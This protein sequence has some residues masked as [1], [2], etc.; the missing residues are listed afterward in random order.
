[1]RIVFTGGTFA[2]KTSLLKLFE[3]NG[4]DTINDVGLE[5]ITKLNGEIGQ[6]KQKQFRKEHPL[7]FY[8]RVINSQLQYEAMATS[9]MV[10]ID[11]GV[12]DYLAM[13]KAEQAPTAPIEKLIEHVK[14][15][16]VFVFD[17]LTNFEERSSTG[18]LYTRKD[19]YKLNKLTKSI[20]EDYGFRVVVVKEMPLSDRYSFVVNEIQK[21]PGGTF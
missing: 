5:V 18:R 2:G 13:M 21:F 12:Y 6:E 19:S 10:I 16:M 3:E 17:T 9:G 11:R 20:Y 4:F 15:D 1:M 14:Y 7:D 8:S